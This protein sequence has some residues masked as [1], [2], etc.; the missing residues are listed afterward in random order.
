MAEVLSDKAVVE[1][2]A[3]PSL[4]ASVVATMKKIS[5]PDA[6]PFLEAA[7]QNLIAA[8][9]EPVDG[10]DAARAAKLTR[11]VMRLTKTILEPIFESPVGA[12]YLA[13]VLWTQRIVQSGIL[14]VCEGSSFLNGWNSLAENIGNDL[15]EVSGL[16]EQALTLVKR[17]EAGYH[18]QG[19]FINL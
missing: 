6:Q 14:D 16:E 8:I 18:G 9:K 3:I 12:Q 10:I 1:L 2:M 5:G 7:S 19:Y 13:T 17:I 4:L 11:R 15:L